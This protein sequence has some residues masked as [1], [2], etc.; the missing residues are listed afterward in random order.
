M[1]HMRAI[2]HEMMKMMK[3]LDNISTGVAGITLSGGS[4]DEEVLAGPEVLEGGFSG[5]AGVRCK[6]SFVVDRTNERRKERRKDRM[7]EE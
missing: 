5:E 3:I 4:L 7:N 2:S 6:K 1:V